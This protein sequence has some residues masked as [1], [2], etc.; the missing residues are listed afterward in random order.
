M[1][2]IQYLEEPEMCHLHEHKQ[3]A[4]GS[5]IHTPVFSHM[6]QVSRCLVL[7]QMLTDA[8]FES[9]PSLRQAN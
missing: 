8:M 1:L 4:D 2:N 6:C 3:V 7:T 9:C 5:T